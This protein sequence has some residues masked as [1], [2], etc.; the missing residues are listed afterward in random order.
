MGISIGQYNRRQDEKRRREKQG[1]KKGFVNKEV[2]EFF[3]ELGY[4]VESFNN[5]RMYRIDGMVDV[6]TKS[7]KIF[8][9]RTQ[10]WQ[11]TTRDSII[12]LITTELKK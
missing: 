11:L 8:I 4:D 1:K 7:P 3:K 2:I 12:Q 10:N 6:F 9:H 5:G